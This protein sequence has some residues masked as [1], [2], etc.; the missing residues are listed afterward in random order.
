[1]NK[2]R[3]DRGLEIEVNDAG[4]TICIPMDDMMFV[5]NFNDLI[6]TFDEVEKELE[7][8]EGKLTEKEELRLI[9]DKTKTIMDKINT[10]FHDEK[11]CIKVF[12]DIVPAPWLLADFF[13]Q[14]LPYV[15]QHS[16]AR[17]KTILS[18]YSNKRRGARSK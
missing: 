17:Q 4:E 11:C 2:I 16:D 3:V 5:A 12:G 14:L 10:L 1:M 15:K 6:E 7:E 9:V 13:E 18:K 8:K